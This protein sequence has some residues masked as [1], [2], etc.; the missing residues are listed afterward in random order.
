M[1]C[2]G[3]R[4]TEIQRTLT[5]SVPAGIAAPTPSS[6]REFETAGAYFEYVGRTALTV[7]GPITGKS[8]RFGAPGERVTVDARDAPALTAVP[9][10]RRRQSL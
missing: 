6:R 10:L 3:K 7:R 9:N 2:C 1:S 5:N 8:Y 4:R